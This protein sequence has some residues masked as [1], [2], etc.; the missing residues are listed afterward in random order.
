MTTVSFD[1]GGSAPPYDTVS[2]VVVQPDDRIV[3]V[4]QAQIPN[5]P[6]DVNGLPA[7]A[8]VARLNADGTLDTSFNGSGELLYRYDLGGTSDD[9]ANGVALEGTEIVIVGT[10]THVPS[11]VDDSTPNPFASELT[12]TCLNADGTFDASFNDS[13]KYAMVLNQGGIPYNTSGGALMVLPGGNLLVGGEARDQN[14]STTVG[15]V[16]L[17]DMTPSGV[18]DASYGTDGVVLLGQLRLESRLLVQSDGKVLFDTD[19]GVARTTAPPAVVTTITTPGTCENAEPTG[20]SL[21][22]NTAIYPSLAS[23][24]SAIVVRSLK[25]KKAIKIKKGGIT[26]GA[27]TQTLTIRFARKTAV[28]KGL[29]LQV[30]PGGIAGDDGQV[31]FHGAGITILIAPS[32]S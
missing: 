27:A 12:V 20:V 32:T 14:E 3:L 19:N 17:A 11:T 21:A 22:F 24:L 31:L 4:G 16:L 6:T 8:A 7:D 30:T 5:Y 13:G 23:D 18:L 28:G 15:S 9:I 1:L 2:G 25:G 10:S 29:R 26:Y